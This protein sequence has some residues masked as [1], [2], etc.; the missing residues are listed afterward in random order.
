MMKTALLAATTLITL[1]A[2][3][4]AG[5]SWKEVLKEVVLASAQPQYVYVAEPSYCYTP[6][7]VIYYA[8]PDRRC[9]Q[10]QRQ[11]RQPQV[12]IIEDRIGQRWVQPRPW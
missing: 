1:A 7:R 8:Q 3:S 5:P 12:A 11:C 4:Q 2:S 9:Y 6:P 10:Q